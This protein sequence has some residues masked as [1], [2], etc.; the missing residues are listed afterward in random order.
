MKNDL[1]IDLSEEEI[2]S[3][4][5]HKFKKIIKEKLFE[6]ANEYL[7]KLKEKHSKTENL[8][9]FKFQ[10]YLYCQNLSIS[11]KKLLFS[12]R[13]RMFNVKTNYRKKYEYNM[14]CSLCQDKTDEESEKHLLKCIKILENASNPS[15][16]KRAIY[17]DIFSNDL[18]KQVTITK[19]FAKIVKI[20]TLVQTQQS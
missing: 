19:I 13:T 10:E 9:T 18:E 5:K 4:K 6:K 12:L 20:R 2:K 8:I 3:I 11:E 15:E 14:H 1:N 7:S 16:I 17:E